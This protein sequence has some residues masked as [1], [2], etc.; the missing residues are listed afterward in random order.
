MEELKCHKS[1]RRILD[2]Q[3]VNLLGKSISYW[4]TNWCVI[5]SFGAKKRSGNAIYM[6]NFHRQNKKRRG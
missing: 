5:F 2:C 1:G 3:K 6:A 4:F